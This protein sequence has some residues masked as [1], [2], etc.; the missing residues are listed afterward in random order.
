MYVAVHVLYGVIHYLMLKLIKPFV[1]KQRIGV[2]RGTGFD[3]LANF[4]LKRFLLR[5]GITLVRTLLFPSLPRSRIPMTAVLSFPPVPVILRARFAS[6][7]VARLAADESFVGF[8]VAREFIG[9]AIPSASANPVIHE[10][11]GFLRHADSAVNLVG[12]D[13]VLA[14]HNLPHGEQP[15]VQAERGIFEDRSGLGSELPPIVFLAALPAVVLR[16][17]DY[18][19]ASATRAGDA[20]RAS[21]AP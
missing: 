16:L 3:M 20:V 6:V 19:I 11:C 17:E 1:R 15:L 4:G 13:A 14:V 12:T 9:V 21:D 5:F 18:A 2:Q 7:H 8:N 10:P